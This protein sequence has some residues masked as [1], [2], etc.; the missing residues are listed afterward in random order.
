MVA[1]TPP[2]GGAAARRAAVQHIIDSGHMERILAA[3]G[4]EAGMIPT[5]EVNPQP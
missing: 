1:A 3:W 4:N 2:P 5:A